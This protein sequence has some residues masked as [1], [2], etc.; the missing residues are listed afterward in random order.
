V[1]KK[2]TSSEQRIYLVRRS[3]VRRTQ[4]Q[5]NWLHGRVAFCLRSAAESGSYSTRMERSE[6][7]ST[8]LPAGAGGGEVYP[9]IGCVAEGRLTRSG[10]GLP[11]GG[12]LD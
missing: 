4:A 5:R 1:Q 10:G 8:E 2:N 6:G 12:V 11:R 3:A 9:W 7:S